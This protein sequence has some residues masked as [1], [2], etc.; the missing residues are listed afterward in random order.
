MTCGQPFLLP[1][2]FSRAVSDT[3]PRT[4][5]T[6]ELADDFSIQLVIQALFDENLSNEGEHLIVANHSRLDESTSRSSEASSTGL[7]FELHGTK[8]Y[9]RSENFSYKGRD[10]KTISRKKKI[11]EI[12]E[13]SK[14]E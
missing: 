3:Y 10:S 13:I 12:S 7:S 11:T 9:F 1:P 2:L 4:M 6:S 14:K 5:Q 8:Q